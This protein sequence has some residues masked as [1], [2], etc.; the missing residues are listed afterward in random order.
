VN[1]RDTAHAIKLDAALISFDGNKYRLPG[2]QDPS[3]R[4]AFV[5]QLIESIRRVRYVTVISAREISAH[6]AD[7][8]SD[9][10]DPIKA[11][12]LHKSA[13]RI[14][15]AFWLVFLSVHFGRHR[16]AGWRL[17]RD[18][19]GG[20]NGGPWTWDRT[21]PNPKAFRDWLASQ[22]A[23]LASDGVPRPF[24]N[25]RK[26]QSLDAR[27][28]AGT[29]AAVES[30]VKWV[31][32]PR[33]HRML[34]DNARAQA[35]DDPRQTFDLL[36]RSMRAVVSFGRT[37]RFDYLTM[38]AKLGL[39]PIEAGSAYLVGATGPID[40]ALL[41]FGENRKDAAARRSLDV[42]LVELGADIG[43]CMQVIEDALCNWQKSPKAFR[44][45]R[46]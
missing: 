44:A 30:Y 5:A 8:L 34:V 26:Y 2:I 46:G 31:D 41:L 45:F 19:Y 9:M 40:G 17:A 10:F 16:R 12:L 36:Y 24:G 28:P 6:R 42:K 35:G 32:P 29:G 20:G 23:S 13:G 25:H 21:S 43:V 11:A 18:I 3:H 37:A 15:E 33:T 38:V 7:P 1:G 39:A 22:Q 27:K 14:D 4:K